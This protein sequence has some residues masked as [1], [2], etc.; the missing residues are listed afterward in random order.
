MKPTYNK[1]IICKKGIVGG[2]LID[3]ETLH[4]RTFSPHGEERV[5]VLKCLSDYFEALPNLN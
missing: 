5:G 1:D 4:D 3:Q 2:N